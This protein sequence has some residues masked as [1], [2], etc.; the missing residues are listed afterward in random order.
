MGR[1][2]NMGGG[3]APAVALKNQTPSKGENKKWWAQQHTGA[4]CLC[5]ELCCLRLSGCRKKG[6]SMPTTTR[7]ET[8]TSC[9][10]WES[11]RR[12]AAEGELHR[13]GE[14]GNKWL[15]KPQHGHLRICV[16]SSLSDRACNDILIPI[17]GAGICK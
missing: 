12:K 7:S 9:F 10:A 1:G 14:A 4:L 3:S 5:G 6:R 17:R 13:R 2:R 11:G 16:I 15:E 8:S